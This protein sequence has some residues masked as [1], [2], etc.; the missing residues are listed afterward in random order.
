M[1][2]LAGTP[3]EEYA[4]SRSEPVPDLLGQ[5]EQETCDVMPLAMML[6]G[7][8][9]GRFLK[10]MVKLIAA[11]RV[12]EIGMFTGYSALSM[13]ESLPADGE[14]VTC[15]I[16]PTAIAFARRYFAA[17]EHGSKITIQEG[18]A[19]QTL[20]KLQGPFDLAF[21]DADKVNYSNY[22]EAVL[23]M[24]RSGGLILVDNVFYGGYVLN[25]NDDNSRAIAT[26]NDL[27]A[28]D[29]RVNCVMLPIR[30]GVSVIRI[31]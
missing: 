31:K 15:E 26:F 25:P 18:P 6:T 22:Y 23:P 14:L 8:L 4:C 28:S 24:I 30:D 3:M 2:K 19:L 13:A 17:S 7:A 16:D 29:V 21:I 10:M 20:Q 9:E 27:V 1:P 12:L 11:R 5:L